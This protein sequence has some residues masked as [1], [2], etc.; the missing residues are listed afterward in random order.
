MLCYVMQLCMELW[1]D[2]FVFRLV[3]NRQFIWIMATQFW[4]SITIA[5][6]GAVPHADSLHSLC[7]HALS[8]GI[9][10]G[11]DHSGVIDLFSYTLGPRHG[12]M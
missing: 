11:H 4:T 5:W 2:H 3:A 6:A 7:I 8:T 10:S 1:M 12:C 9:E